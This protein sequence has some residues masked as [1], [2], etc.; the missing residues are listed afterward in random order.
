MEK[1]KKE[2]EREYEKERRK[3]KGI[4][5]GNLIMYAQK[6]EDNY[7]GIESGNSGGDGGS[8]YSTGRSSRIKKSLF[9][10]SEAS[11]LAKEE[12]L[13]RRRQRRRCGG[14]TLHRK[15]MRSEREEN[16]REKG[17]GREKAA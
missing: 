1:K 13:S 3:R 7:T 6:K 9:S 2:K 12:E 8:S 11:S 10:L 16:K 14:R 5:K 17:K 4:W 15:G